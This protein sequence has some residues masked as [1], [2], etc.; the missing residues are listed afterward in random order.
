MIE[1]VFKSFMAPPTAIDLYE[2]KGRAI[3]ESKISKFTKCNLPIQMT[4]LGFPFKS[5]NH[6]DKT[7]GVLPDYGEEL[8][9]L[10]FRNMSE[11]IKE[12]YKPG[13]KLT[14]ISDGYI[15]NHLMDVPDKE[16]QEYEEVVRDMSGIAPIEVLNPWDFYDRGMSMN[17][18]REKLSEQFGITELE[19]E[20]RILFDPEVKA[21]Y[22]GMIRFMQDDLAILNYDSGNQLHK[23]AKKMARQ[24]MIWNE[25]Y[26]ALIRTQL[27]EPLGAIRLS[28]H[29]SQNAGTKYSIKLIDAERANQSPWHSVIAVDADGNIATM[30]RKAAEEAGFE[31]QYKNNQPYYYETENRYSNIGI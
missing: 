9:M 3:L 11:K 1:Q 7:L 15:F 27:T 18:I 28:M 13:I 12:V 22:Q 14:I 10:N 16:V 5:I 4:L 25:A 30:K 23:A 24:M 29:P 31:L 8:S 6:R 17:S 21:L 20:K 19:L 26:S 2:E